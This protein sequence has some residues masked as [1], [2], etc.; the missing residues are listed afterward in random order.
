MSSKLFKK[1]RKAARTEAREAVGE[2]IG[3]LSHYIHKR[4]KWCPRFVFIVLYM[5]IFKKKLWHVI[6]KHL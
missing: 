4:P 1:I 5:P 6:Y 2:G 3:A